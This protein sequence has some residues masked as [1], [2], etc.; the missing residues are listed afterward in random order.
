M[1]RS[2]VS[3]C[4]A[5]LS[6]LVLVAPAAAA[7]RTR[8]GVD[9]SEWSSDTAAGPG[10]Y[11]VGGSGQV[12]GHFVTGE[13]NGVQIAI[14]AQRRFAQ[15]VDPL[16]VSK[17]KQVGVYEVETG[18]SDGAGRAIWNYDIHVDMRDARG[19]AK[20]TVLG[21][22]T[23]VLDADFQPAFFGCAFPCELTGGA[24]DDALLFQ[25]SQNPEF[26]DGIDAV[27]DFDATVEG[28]Y[29]VTLILTPDTFNGPPISVTMRVVV[30]DPA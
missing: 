12:N 14:R 3:L 29:R 11:P 23:L 26:G 19:V 27:D 5:V 1:K 7:E 25:M 8:F 4:I 20:G 24:I 9:A 16:P 30:S 15:N 6:M 13:R 2:G 18:T 21:D 10:I 28:D 22:Y 17:D